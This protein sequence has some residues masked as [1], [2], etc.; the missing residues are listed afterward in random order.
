MLKPKIGGVVGVIIGIVL[1]A[2]CWYEVYQKGSFHLW[3]GL[4]G[5]AIIPSSL[6]MILVPI[7]RLFTPEIRDNQEHYTYKFDTYKPLSWILFILGGIL[8]AANYGLLKYGFGIL[9]A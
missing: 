6:A 2:L 1:I 9:Q 8:A 4:V 3:A 7:D 5:P